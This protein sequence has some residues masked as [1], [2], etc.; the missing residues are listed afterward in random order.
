MSDWSVPKWTVSLD[1]DCLK[2]AAEPGTTVLPT[3]PPLSVGIGAAGGVSLGGGGSSAGRFFEQPATAIRA[4]AAFSVVFN[5]AIIAFYSDV[6]V[7]APL[8]QDRHR[9]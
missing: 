4:V 3:L 7:T 2:S 8:Q 1:T 6:V 9:P 5:L